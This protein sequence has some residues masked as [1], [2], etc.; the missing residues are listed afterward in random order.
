MVESKE[1]GRLC[2]QNRLSVEG[3]VWEG[4]WALWEEQ[5]DPGF[6]EMNE[7]MGAYGAKLK[8]KI[9]RPLIPH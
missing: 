6:L 5:E 8:E 4:L 9:H 3:H 7:W 2:C 1:L